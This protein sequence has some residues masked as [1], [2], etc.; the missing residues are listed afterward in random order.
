MPATFTT[1]P[2]GARLP[3]RMT[4]PPVGLSGFEQRPDDLLVRR[5]R[6]VARVVGDGP[7]GDG[8]RIGVQEAAVEQAPRDQ[9]NAAGAVQIGRDE[10]AARLEVGEQRHAAAD[11]VEVVDVERHARLVRDRQQ[12]QH[13]VGRAAGGGDR[14]DRVLERRPA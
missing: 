8:D 14:G 11:A 3:L 7:S 2:S 13:R 5:L 12:V 10:P 6:G 9:R 1:A 4:R